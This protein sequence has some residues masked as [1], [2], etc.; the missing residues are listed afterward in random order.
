V[1]KNAFKN[2]QV[3]K[4]IDANPSTI[5]STRV[6]MTILLSKYATNTLVTTRMILKSSLD[7]KELPGEEL[8]F[9]KRKSR[10]LSSS[11]QSV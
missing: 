6:V 8:N 4:C 11:R 9:S 3:E 2:F 7:K 1:T 5:T 10:W